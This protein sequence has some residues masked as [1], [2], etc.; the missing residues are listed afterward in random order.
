MAK[1][2]QLA[3][4]NK[5]H[6]ELSVSSS[7]YRA[8][9]VNTQWHTFKT[10]TANIKAETMKEFGKRSIVPTSE[11]KEE[12]ENAASKAFTNI[13]TEIKKLRNDP[14]VM[15]DRKA[16]YLNAK[17]LR[18]V[19]TTYGEPIKKAYRAQLDPSVTF[20]RI[21]GIYKEAMQQY[22]KDLQLITD[23]A[24]RKKSK[25][26]KSGKLNKETSVGKFFHLGHLDTMGVVETQLRDS[27]GKAFNDL[28]LEEHGN[29]TGLLE[30][31]GIDLSY[32]R[33]DNKDMM[34]V[35]IE[36]ATDNMARGGKLG[37]TKKNLLSALRSAM[38][39]FNPM[40]VSGS[41]TPRQRKIKQ[42]TK[43]LTEPFEKIKSS[44]LKVK[45]IKTTLKKS[46]SKKQTL[47]TEQKALKSSKRLKVGT[48]PVSKA[49]KRKETASPASS[50]LHLMVAINKKLPQVVAQNMQSPALNYRTGRFSSSVKVT[51]V[52]RTPR[53]YPSFGYTYDKFPYQTFEVGHAQGDPE[54]D[55]RKLI[56]QSIREIAAEMAIGRFFTRRV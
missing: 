48:I 16:T 18:L 6:N 39:K 27:L 54:R 29:I 5:L 38:E 24:I 13:L 1:A 11:Q 15:I 47:S 40:E 22:F 43:A 49:P 33:I 30:Q 21:K 23:N 31:H 50:P 46:S 36:S 44:S 8:L 34:E 19:F 17:R 26:K 20:D 51:D 7:D 28:P 55:P 56:N 3:F 25:S 32:Q 35:K 42:A 41:D 2:R 4:L 45:T 53:G 37:T 10:S 14:Q 9:V 52:V 12:V